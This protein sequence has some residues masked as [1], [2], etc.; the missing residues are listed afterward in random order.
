MKKVEKLFTALL[1]LLVAGVMA[2]SF[3]SCSS[4]DDDDDVS[5][6]A[7]YKDSEAT[8]TDYETV[9]FYSDNT[10]KGHVYSKYVEEGF[11]LIV[12]LDTFIG[13]YSV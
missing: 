4:D 10:V 12:N 11:S 1:A 5:T 13:T 8:D 6:V 3:V 9:T 2:T 7:V